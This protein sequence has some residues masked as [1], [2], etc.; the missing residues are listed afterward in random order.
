MIKK[1]FSHKGSA[2]S[3]D[4]PVVNPQFKEFEVNN[5][6]LSGFIIDKL[7]PIVGYHPYPLNELLL[8]TGALCRIHPDHLFEWGTHL[9]KSA[10]IFFETRQRFQLKTVI[11]SVDLPPDVS[12]IEH[13]GKE[14]AKFLKGIQGVK[15]YR[16]DGLEIATKLG[17]SFDP[18]AILMFFLDGDHS[19]ESVSRELEILSASFPSASILVHD[20]FYQDP[21]CGYN[22][23]PYK[24]I[25]QLLG[26]NPSRYRLIETCTGLPGMSLLLPS[27][28]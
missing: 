6:D 27:G 14:Y 8:M 16:G 21:A 17:K 15:L 9:G 10:R 13:P 24:A 20:T 3:A 19:F 12:H 26:R 23:G 28:I 1:I 2:R 5:W 22:I 11:H 25:Q 7:L 18:S 4:I